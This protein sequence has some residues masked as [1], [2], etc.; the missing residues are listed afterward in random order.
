MISEIVIHLSFSFKDEINPND[1]LDKLDLF[2]SVYPKL[3][4]S[5]YSKGEKLLHCRISVNDHTLN[6]TLY[7]I[8]DELTH[9]QNYLLEIGYK[10]LA[11][12]D[13]NFEYSDPVSL[14]INKEVIT[15]ILNIKFEYPSISLNTASKNDNLGEGIEYYQLYF[16]T[17]KNES[18]NYFPNI[19]SLWKT[20]TSDEFVDIESCSVLEDNYKTCLILNLKYNFEDFEWDELQ[21]KLFG[22][23]KSQK[24]KLNSNIEVSFGIKHYNDDGGEIGSE[25][26]IES[27]RL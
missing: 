27:S 12:I 1:V 7:N 24:D 25:I 8:L 18:K 6:N 4:W 11:E 23:Y 17:A 14:T 10:Y 26:L 13:L 19:K 15:K 22:F 3:Y 9:K 21:N 16:C 2:S 20:Y 5:K